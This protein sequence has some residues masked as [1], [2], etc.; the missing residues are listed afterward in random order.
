[1]IELYHVVQFI[2]SLAGCVS[3]FVKQYF[4]SPSTHFSATNSLRQ[5]A[6]NNQRVERA[7]TNTFHYPTLQIL[8]TMTMLKIHMHIINIYPLQHPSTSQ[9]HCQ[10]DMNRPQGRT[11]PLKCFFGRTAGTAKSGASRTER[12]VFRWGSPNFT[13]CFMIH[14]L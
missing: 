4:R 8:H 3:A 11:K 2:T 1:M 14:T 7:M 10:P 5:D 13:E 9:Y 12:D 6:M